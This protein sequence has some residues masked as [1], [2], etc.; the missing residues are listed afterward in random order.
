MSMKSSFCMH[1]EFRISKWLLTVSLIFL[2]ITLLLVWF[3]MKVVK[4]WTI[5]VHHSPRKPQNNRETKSPNLI[6]RGTFVLQVSIVVTIKLFQKKAHSFTRVLYGF[7]D[8]TDLI[9]ILALV[10][11]FQYDSDFCTFPLWESCYFHV[12]LVVFSTCSK[13]QNVSLTL[14]YSIYLNLMAKQHWSDIAMW[15]LP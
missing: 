5:K 13:W 4:K 2:Q 14:K 6:Q 1:V 9:V 3:N 10:Q 7:K 8:E 12:S 11:L 15:D